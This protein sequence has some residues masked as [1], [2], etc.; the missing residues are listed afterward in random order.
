MARYKLADKRR[1]LRGLENE[2]VPEFTVSAMR[3][4]RGAIAKVRNELKDL[5]DALTPEVG[6]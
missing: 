1:K 2:I 4:A 5:E 3:G 6:E